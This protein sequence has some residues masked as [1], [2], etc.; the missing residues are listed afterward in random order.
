MPTTRRRAMT[1]IRSLLL[2]AATLGLAACTT[3]MGS[4]QG[5]PMVQ[6]LP[7]N[8]PAVAGKTEV[9]WLGQATTRITTP[10][11]KVIVIDPW[12]TSNPKTPAAWKDLKALG[13]VDL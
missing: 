3:P 2:A 7:G 10:G 13:K 6:A 11:G 1:P 5:A 12:L 4:M 8:A 9:L